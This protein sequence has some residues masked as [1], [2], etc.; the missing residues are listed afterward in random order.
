VVCFCC[1]A[2]FPPPQPLSSVSTGTYRGT[3]D[4]HIGTNVPRRAAPSPRPVHRRLSLADS[5]YWNYSVDDHALD[6]LA[7]L[8]TVRR[9]KSTVAADDSASAA[10][11]EHVPRSFTVVGV[12]HS[13]GGCSLLLYTLLCSAVGI[14]H[15][16]SRYR[17]RVVV[18]WRVIT[19]PADDVCIFPGWC[20]FRPPAFTKTCRC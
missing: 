6:V 5:A 11:N 16:L 14:D 8:Q 18:V 15:G 3:S 20:C 19:F 13:M 7:S 1:P 9:L 10:S 4:D 12:G 17:V 2:L